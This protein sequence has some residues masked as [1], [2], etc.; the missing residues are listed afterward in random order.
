VVKYPP[1]IAF[2]LITTGVNL[3]VLGLFA[4]AGAGLQWLLQRLAVFGRVP[5]FFYLTHLFLYAGL[6]HWLTPGGTSVPRMLPL[7]LLG[8]AVLYP[9]C[10]WYG[11][12]KQRQGASL[13]LR[14]L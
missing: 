13:I 3:L 7:W 1:S 8:L 11:R 12:L 2:T 5:L 6:G 4:R 14:F 10:L 9:L